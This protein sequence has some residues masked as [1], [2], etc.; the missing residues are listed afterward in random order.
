MVGDMKKLF[1]GGDELELVVE[2]MVY[3]GMCKKSDEGFV[4]NSGYSK[5]RSIYGC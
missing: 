5:K 4:G 3:E 2:K 1:K